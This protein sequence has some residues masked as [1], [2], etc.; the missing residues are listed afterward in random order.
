MLVVVFALAPAF[1][2]Q[3]ATLR[4]LPGADA[5]PKSF[6]TGKSK[7]IRLLYTDPKGDSI[8]AKDAQFI[9]QSPS[10]QT[11]TEA[12]RISGNPATGATIEWVLNDLEQGAHS[13]HFEIK[14][15]DDTVVRY[16]EDQQSRY[17]FV[18]ESP[19]TKWIIMGVGGLISWLAL[20]LIVYLLAR[21]LNPRGDP[22]RAAKMGLLIGILASCALFI[23]LFLS[24]YGPLVFAILI[25]GF[26]GAI[27]L[28]LR[29]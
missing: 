13:A 21:N 25:V 27:V 24:L 12:T 14:T 29:R 26:L 16:P 8:K 3:G 17:Q 10:G 28:L 7:T 18:V 4:E 15:L 20:P 5:L 19:L 1:A 23:Y 2:R 6:Q 9:D 11:V 22:S